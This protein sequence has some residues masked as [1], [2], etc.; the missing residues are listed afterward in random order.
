MCLQVHDTRDLFVLKQRLFAE[1]LRRFY[2]TD[3]LA[4]KAM[5]IQFG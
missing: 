5:I 2:L 4:T 3:V 1:N